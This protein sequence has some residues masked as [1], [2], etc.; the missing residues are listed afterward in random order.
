MVGYQPRFGRCFAQ[1]FT[2]SLTT[3]HSMICHRTRAYHAQST[4]FNQ[5]PRGCDSHSKMSMSMSM[6]WL[7]VR[8][9]LGFSTACFMYKVDRG[10]A[11]DCLSAKFTRVHEISQRSTRQSGDIYIPRVSTTAGKMSLA[12]RGGKLWNSL[13]LSLRQSTTL[14]VFKQQYYRS[15]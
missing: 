11:P 8:N 7:N 2:I 14:N 3:A 6:G 1:R 5:F 10:M 12:Y 15:S 4:R 13:P 9:R